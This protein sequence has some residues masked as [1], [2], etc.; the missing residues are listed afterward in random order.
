MGFWGKKTGLRKQTAM[1]KVQGNQIEDSPPQTKDKH[2]PQCLKGKGN[3]NNNSKAI[4]EL[5][6]RYR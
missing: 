4:Y 1:V 6:Q 5:C 2:C 3:P